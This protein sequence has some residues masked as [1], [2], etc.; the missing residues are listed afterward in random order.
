MHLPCIPC[1]CRSVRSVAVLLAT[2]LH[3]DRKTL[4]LPGLDTHAVMVRTRVLGGSR[5]APG[6]HRGVGCRHPK[7]MAEN[8]LKRRRPPGNLGGLLLQGRI[9]LTEVLSIRTFCGNLMSLKSTVSSKIYDLNSLIFN[10]LRAMS[11]SRQKAS[12]STKSSS[13]RR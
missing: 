10:S 7:L 8:D 2:G 6:P 5:G 12:K 9:V 13:F 4:V 3:S 11:T 1:F